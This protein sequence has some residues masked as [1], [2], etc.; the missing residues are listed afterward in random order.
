MTLPTREEQAKALY[1]DDDKL[2]TETRRKQA[3]LFMEIRDKAT[4]KELREHL[5]QYDEHPEKC[6][7]W[8]IIIEELAE[9]LEGEKVTK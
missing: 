2:G 3:M 4:A 8:V 1:P 7:D 6:E 9:Q 5:K